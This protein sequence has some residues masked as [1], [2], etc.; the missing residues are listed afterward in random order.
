MGVMELRQMKITGLVH[1]IAGI[2]V[3]LLPVSAYKFSSHFVKNIIFYIMGPTAIDSFVF[4]LFIK[5]F[6]IKL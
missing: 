5:T 6:L 2:T 3:N 1:Y 4:F